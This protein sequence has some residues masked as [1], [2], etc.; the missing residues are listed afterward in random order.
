M[1]AIVPLAVLVVAAGPKLVGAVGGGDGQTPT[2]K[3]FA[4]VCRA[5]GGTP[6]FAAGSGDYV[7]DARDCTIEYG[8]DSYEIYAVHPNGFS[9]REAAQAH[10]ACTRLAAQKRR[11][12]ARGA[13][14]GSVRVVWHQRSGI[15]ESKP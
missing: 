13:Q 14:P 10:K 4:K 15:C 7:K 6:T 1:A 11:D 9:E 2:D 5:H 12:A 3:A 8:G